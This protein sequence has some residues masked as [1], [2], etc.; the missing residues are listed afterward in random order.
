[1]K[2]VT[3]KRR[4]ETQEEAKYA[5]RESMLFRNSPLLNVYSCLYCNFGWHLTS[6]QKVAKKQK[7]K[8]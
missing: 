1:M 4:Y 6:T 5:A 3:G 8:K 7:R 2:C